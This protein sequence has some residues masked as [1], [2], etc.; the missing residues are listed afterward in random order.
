MLTLPDLQILEVLAVQGDRDHQEP[1]VGQGAHSGHLCQVNLWSLQRNKTYNRLLNMEGL[2][3]GLICHAQDSTGEKALSI[4]LV[5]T[6][7]SRLSFLGKSLVH[8][9]ASRPWDCTLNLA[10]LSC[11][12]SISSFLPFI[13]P[14]MLGRMQGHC[15]HP[16]PEMRTLRPRETAN[17]LQSRGK[18]GLEARFPV[19]QSWAFSIVFHPPPDS[20]LSTAC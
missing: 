5:L 14:T 2:E 1:Q 16:M 10:F 17:L 3:E 8:V 19:S 12:T 7:S 15:W 9:G 4:M 18:L 11:F 13:L 20:F 6:L